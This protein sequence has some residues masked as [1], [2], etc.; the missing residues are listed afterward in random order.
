LT[1]TADL[2]LTRQELCYCIS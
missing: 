1:T 2:T